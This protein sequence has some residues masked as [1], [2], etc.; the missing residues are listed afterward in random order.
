MTVLHIALAQMAPRKGEFEANLAEVA[1]TLVRADALDPRPDVVHFPETATSGY[2]LEGGVRD[3]AMSAEDL[4]RH[5]DRAY[6]DAMA[7]AGRGMRPIDIVIG[8]YER[9][10]DTL[11]NSAMYVTV[12][13]ESA[14]TIR[15]VH[16]KVFL[17]TY[18][19]FDEDRFV[20]PGYEVRAFDTSW[21]RAAL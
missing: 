20:E 10:Q 17:P 2:F 16:R 18:G 19:M 15:H 5:L 7:Q 8:F 1:S 12:G 3:A 13:A 11:Y 4:A 14:A 9:W 21:G 6:R